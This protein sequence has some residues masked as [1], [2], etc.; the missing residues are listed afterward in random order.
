MSP[1]VLDGWITTVTSWLSDFLGGVF[2][3]LVNPLISVCDIVVEWL[4]D[5]LYSLF[6]S[7]LRNIMYI[8]LRLVDFFESIFS[9]LSGTDTV[10][11]D[12]EEMYLLDVFVSHDSIRT[13]LTYVI[14][15]GIAL[16]F[17]FTIYS[18]TKSIGSYALENKHPVGEVMKNAL[19]ACV[20]FA[21]IPIMMMFGIQL[22]SAL[23]VSTERAVMS[24]YGT[25]SVPSTSTVIFLSG[26]FGDSK[27]EGNS[28]TEGIRGKYYRG[29]PDQYG[30]QYS[31]YNDSQICRDFHMTPS[32]NW[33]Y[34]GTESLTDD[35]LS[36]IKPTPGDQQLGEWNSTLKDKVDNSAAGKLINHASFNFVFVYLACIV[37]I[38]FMLCAMFV[39]IRRIVEVIVLY[40][41]AP[42]YV[43]AMPLDGGAAFGKWRQ[44]FIGKLFTGFGIV[45]SMKLV[46]M[47]T[48]IIFTPNLRLCGTSTTADSILKTIFMVASFYAAWKSSTLITELISPEAAMAER[49]GMEVIGHMARQAAMVGI[50]AA[51]GGAGAAAGA[52]NAGNAGN[53][54]SAAGNSAGKTAGSAAGKSSGA[55]TGG[56][57]SPGR[58]NSGNSL[59]SAMDHIPELPE[60]DEEKR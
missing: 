3:A 40:I 8:L 19:K 53:A 55:F 25:D 35:Q 42:F 43:S 6:G 46:F 33:S 45:I 49:D 14:F 18:V 57:G 54:A 50:A 27:I 26:T 31:I 36:Q 10:T 23:L 29:E 21:I 48:P 41:T 39:F 2:R 16:C 20:S 1:I 52:G 13:A 59:S 58:F 24:A 22:S 11:Y 7:A 17:I 32:I 15:I 12:G 51:T 5:A 56:T 44:M 38:I 34:S 30:E 47:L 37:I 4:M 9:M 28:F 60:P